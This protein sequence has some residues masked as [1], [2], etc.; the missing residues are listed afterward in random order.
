MIDNEND[1]LKQLPTRT[2]YSTRVKNKM[3]YNDMCDDNGS[4]NDR[5]KESAVIVGVISMVFVF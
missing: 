2:V 4:I 1:I 5:K 3:G